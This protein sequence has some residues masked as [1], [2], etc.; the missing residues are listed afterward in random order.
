MVA[1]AA[2]LVVLL[3]LAAILTAGLGVYAYRHREEPGA[4]AFVALMAILTNWSA[5]YAAG[6]MTTN[7][8][9]RIVWLRLVWIS[10]GTIEVWLL[11]FALAYTGHDE[12]VTHKTV[13]TLLIVPGIVI[14]ATWTNPWHHLFWV[15]H[16][17]V[18]ANG[19]VLVNPSWGVLFW[20]EVIYTYLLVAVA[21]ALLIR[22]IY[23]SDYLYTDQS[24]LLLVGIAVPFVASA[25]DVFVFA[26]APAIDPTPYAFTVTGVAFAYALFRRQLF[27]L[28]PATRQLGRNAAI[29]QL[30]AGV[31]IVDN[32][33][34]IVYCNAAAEE[35]LDCNAADAIGRDVELLVDESRLD[36][37][38]ED[39]LAEVHRDDRVYEV[40]TSPVTDRRDQRI[41]NTL[42]VHDVTARKERER[43]LASQR[44]ELETVNDLNAVI[45]GVNQALVSALSREEIE[46]TVCERVADADLYQTAFIGDIATWT[47]EADRWTVAGGDAVTGPPALDHE[48]ETDPDD[49]PSPAAIVPSGED[50][51][52]WTIV[53]LV[54]GRTVYGALGLYTE[55]ESISDRERSVL[56]ELGEII[57]NAIDAVE[58]RQLL[59]A[60]A[61]V[62]LAMECTDRGDPL[63]AATTDLP[64][65]LEL[66]GLV[67]AGEDG[68]LAYLQVSDVDVTTARAAL[69]DIT[70]GV[71]RTIRDG[72]DEGLLEWQVTGDTPLGT[73]V[74]HGASVTDVRADGGRVRYDLDIASEANVRTLVDT[75]AEQFADT[76]VLSKRERTRSVEHMGALPGDGLDDLTDRQ[77]EVLE[78]AY[79]A[80]YFSWP[81]ES[82]A[83]EVAETLD[84]SS[85]TLHSHLRKAEDSLLSDLFDDPGRTREDF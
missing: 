50:T 16:S 26:D 8:F 24:A 85:A 52:T 9:W 53:P 28:V 13:A 80:G 4:S 83:E 68:P 47:G 40:R 5:V 79:R 76:H 37:D 56:G 63:V 7:E 32:A 51:G 54:Y 30:D 2:V 82:N 49:D 11:L 33:N 46:E 70:N 18:Q 81:R 64:G 34:R 65:T 58:T 43:R 62:E 60:E 6:L 45:R 22:L 73:L 44:D 48:F 61:V 15:E 74:D 67:P 69:G 38:T 21:S 35:V 1:I 36:F 42:V 59:S 3:V 84:I 12:F 29:G 17:I 23:Q 20:I 78:A 41:G 75:V 25:A 14:F 66:E 31:V 27:D 57:G 39:A 71:V 10:T 19:L 72:D 77:R 55:R